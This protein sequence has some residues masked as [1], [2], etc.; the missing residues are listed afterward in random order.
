MFLYLENFIITTI[1][2]TVQYF[3]NGKSQICFLTLL[4]IQALN[5]NL[6]DNPGEDNP[7]L[8]YELRYVVVTFKSSRCRYFKNCIRMM[9]ESSS[10]P[11]S[12]K[13]RWVSETRP[14]GLNF[15]QRLGV[16]KVR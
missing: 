4:Q 15:D 10:I 6:T 5:K 9:C 12:A 13:L 8:Q 3:I 14:P 16:G 2:F 1:T 7:S 11:T